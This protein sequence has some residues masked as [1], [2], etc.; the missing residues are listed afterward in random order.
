MDA[1]FQEM[2]DLISK[3]SAL[4]KTLIINDL[5]KKLHND[6][7]NSK[8]ALEML[9]YCADNYLERGLSLICDFTPSPT[10]SQF[11][12]TIEKTWNLCA[13]A[14]KLQGLKATLKIEKE[15]PSVL[16]VDNYRFF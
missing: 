2:R 3:I 16:K 10:Y 14:V 11:Y 7:S 6:I 13:E 8:N 4:F 9:L 15:C 1:F 5:S 12:S